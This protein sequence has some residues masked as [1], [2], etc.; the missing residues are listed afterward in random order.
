M[1]LYMNICVPP[2]S[3][4]VFRIPITDSGGASSSS[5]TACR[6]CGRL[7]KKYKDQKYFEGYNLKRK[8][9]LVKIHHN[10]RIEL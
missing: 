8:R 3:Y 9:E 5:L 6:N 1:K 7:L 4:E 10:R 2:S